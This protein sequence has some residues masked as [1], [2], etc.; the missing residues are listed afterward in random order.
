MCSVCASSYPHWSG[1]RKGGLKFVGA[2]TERIFS[3]PD[4]KPTE[5]AFPPAMKALLP[6]LLLTFA[7]LTVVFAKGGRPINDVCPVE[8][9]PGRPIYRIFTDEGTIIFCCAD[10]VEAYQKNPNRYPV[11]KSEK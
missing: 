5:L 2:L 1:P 11:K 4:A 10:C 8:G 7:S 3:A 9:K 6:A